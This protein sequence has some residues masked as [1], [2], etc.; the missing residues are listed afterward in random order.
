MT[1]E[2]KIELENLVPISGLVKYAKRIGTAKF[3]KELDSKEDINVTLNSCMLAVYNT[4]IIIGGG[5]AIGKG[6]EYLLK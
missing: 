4:V 1:N 2:Y 5:V 6:I 3:K